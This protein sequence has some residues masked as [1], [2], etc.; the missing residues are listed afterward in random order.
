MNLQANTKGDNMLRVAMYK[1]INHYA[2]TNGGHWFNPSTMRAF[3]CRLPDYGYLKGDLYHF[4][5]SEKNFQGERK[6]TLRTMDLKGNIETLGS[7]ADMT[8]TEARRFLADTLGVKVKD[9]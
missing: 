2:L 8:R 1:I 3:S 4:I 7:F 6:F 5:S 9:L